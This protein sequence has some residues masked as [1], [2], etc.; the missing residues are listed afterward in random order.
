MILKL[1]IERFANIPKSGECLINTDSVIDYIPFGSSESLVLFNN[2]PQDRLNGVVHLV[3]SESPPF[4]QAQANSLLSYRN[5]SVPVFDPINGDTTR[6]LNTKFISYA[7][8]SG[9]D[10]SKTLVKYNNGGWFN[11]EF[12]CS[13]TLDELY[14]IIDNSL[15]ITIPATDQ[16]A[17]VLGDETLYKSWLI[18]YNVCLGSD[19]MGKDIFV[20]NDGDATILD[21]IA[22]D[23]I[24]DFDVSGSIVSGEVVL[25]V[26]NSNASDMT[27][28]YIIKPFLA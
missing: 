22:G 25:T 8:P 3:L 7:E 15:S 18:E 24:S 10:G 2:N 19:V 5:I 14:S 26:I 11:D 13:L 27:F 20:V 16:V 4:I 6:Y 9:V 17:I 1:N 21:P 28:R 23:Y 12:L